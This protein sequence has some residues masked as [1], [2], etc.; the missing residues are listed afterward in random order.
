[1]IQEFELSKVHKSGAV[2]DIKKLNWINAQYMKKLSPS[3]FKH[4]VG[5]LEIPDVAVPLIT[6]RLEKMSDVQNFDYFW[7]EPV[8]DKGLLVWKNSSLE[9]VKNSLE[10][11]RK[12][13]EQTKDNANIRSEL[14]ELSKKIGNRGLA[15][16]PLRVALTGKE[17]SPDPVD[18]LQVLGR[19]DTLKRIDIAINKLKV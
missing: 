9:D 10:E 16:W 14:D 17:K 3:E 13:L 18:V 6:E 11:T 2:F 7:K 8:Y 12:I 19:D 15:C 1:M 5:I 4:K